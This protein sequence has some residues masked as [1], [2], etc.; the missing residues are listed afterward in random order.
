M[1]VILYLSTIRVDNLYLERQPAKCH[2]H[3]LKTSSDDS[4][5]SGIVCLIQ[6][7]GLLLYPYLFITNAYIIIKKPDKI[8]KPPQNLF[9]FF[10]VQN[11]GFLFLIA[12]PNSKFRSHISPIAQTSRLLN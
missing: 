7:L 3:M 4:P 2:W 11:F 5:Q 1:A 6:L 9:P 12:V 10:Q 8:H